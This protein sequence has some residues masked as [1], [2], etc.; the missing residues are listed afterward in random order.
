MKRN[1]LIHLIKDTFT[2]EKIGF[3]S[4]NDK[5]L[6]VYLNDIPYVFSI[7][8]EWKKIKNI[9]EKGRDVSIDIIRNCVI[10]CEVKP[11]NSIFVC[12]VECN[13]LVCASCDL[14]II[15][16]NRGISRCSFCNHTYGEELDSWNLNRYIHSIMVEYR[17]N[18]D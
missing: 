15:M 3:N 14:K 4:T 13:Q 17:K 8:M 10:C 5:E 7:H 16:S 11:S 2:N 9:L 1:E 18:F 6:T 12:C